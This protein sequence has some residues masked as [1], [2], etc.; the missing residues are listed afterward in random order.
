MDVW[1]PPVGDRTRVRGRAPR[2]APTELFWIVKNGIRMT[3][4][5]AWH[6]I[7]T[8]DEIWDI[9]AFLK[10]LPAMSPEQYQDLQKEEPLASSSGH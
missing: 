1:G 5:P 7:Y 4:M 8:D 3:G 2:W 9:V 6:E 10:R